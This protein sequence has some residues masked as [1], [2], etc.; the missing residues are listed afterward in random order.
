M[1]LLLLSACLPDGPSGELPEAKPAGSDTGPADTDT[2]TVTDAP[3][4]TDDTDDTSD[5]GA[6]PEDEGELRAVW[7]D[8]WTYSSEADVREIMANSAAAGFNT[9]FF[10]V[11]GN[12]DAYYQS[13][14]EP[15]AA[16]LTGTLGRDPGWDPL[17]VAIEAGHA[18]GL[19][20]HAYINAFPFWAGTTPPPDSTPRHAYLA[21]PDW[22]VAD[23]SGTPMALNA[24]YVWMSPAN[25]GVQ[26][27]LADV[28]ADITNRYDVDGIH[29][30][31]V[32]Y[33]GAAYSHDDV[34]EGAYD[35][36]GWEDWQRAQVVEAVAGVYAVSDVPVTASVWGVY[37]NDWGWSSVSEGRDDYYQDSRAFASEGVIDANIPMIYWP[38]TETPGDRLDFATLIADHVAH[39]NGRHM[40]AGIT[41][42]MDGGEADV[43]ACIEAAR[44]AGASGVALF[45]Y[46]LLLDE[47]YLFDLATGPFAEPK[48][49]PR[50]DWR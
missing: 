49:P 9:V 48:E 13:S 16:R 39:A 11:R 8:R 17:A 12:A 20:V 21:H 31:L 33:P 18:E 27:R 50:Y 28:A 34:S 35:G 36:S 6:L 38:V 22:L 47:G 41:A 14:Y 25:P 15:W 37:T 26:E 10:Q 24:S 19:D 45:D 42:E 3:S 7:V 2:E 46:Q 4:D 29:L 44:A 43:L 30:D 23:T 1:L 5:T 32:R 40:V